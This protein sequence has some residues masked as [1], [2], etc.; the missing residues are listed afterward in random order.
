M[1]NIVYSITI[2]ENNL[3]SNVNVHCFILDELELYL[4][5]SCKNNR[6]ITHVFIT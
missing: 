3:L 5:I 2:T 4:S 1:V 6:R